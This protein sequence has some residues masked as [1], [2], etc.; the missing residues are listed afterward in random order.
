MFVSSLSVL[1]NIHVLNSLCVLSSL[2]SFLSPCPL[3]IC[4]LF[5]MLSLPFLLPMSSPP[6][7]S[8]H[9][10]LQVAASMGATLRNTISITSSPF[11]YH[12]FLPLSFLV[13]L[14]RTIICSLLVALSM[15]PCS[16]TQAQSYQQANQCSSRTILLSWLTPVTRYYR[17]GHTR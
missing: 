16:V 1:Y 8:S 17:P 11:S 12:P 2:C 10:S 5:P 3:L 4:P 6:Y 13:F 9:P 14:H 7:V 15:V